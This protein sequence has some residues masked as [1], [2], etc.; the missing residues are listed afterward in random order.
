MVSIQRALLGAV[1]DDLIAVTCGLAGT[2]IRIN[3]YF[4]SQPSEESVEEIASVATEV[5]A[6]F[7]EP[8][9][10]REMCYAIPPDHRLEGLDFI[11]FLRAG[12]D[13]LAF[14]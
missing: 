7:S 3:A 9:T 6:D 13:E 14:E 5:I 12:H 2:E 11:A 10:I 8:Y 4:S 1:G